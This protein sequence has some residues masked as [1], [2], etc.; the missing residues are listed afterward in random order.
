MDDDGARGEEVRD[1]SASDALTESQHDEI[2]HV[3]WRRGERD[4]VAA[5]AGNMDNSAE[6]ELRQERPIG[7]DVRG[8]D[9]GRE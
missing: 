7:G 2:V 9:D 8:C 1:L 5:T 6:S 3:D 4:A